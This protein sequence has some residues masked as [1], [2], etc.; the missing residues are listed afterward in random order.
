MFIARENRAVAAALHCLLPL[1]WAC[2]RCFV[3]IW[4]IRNYHRLDF[5]YK[6]F[7]KMCLSNVMTYFVLNTLAQMLQW[8]L[9]VVLPCLG[10]LC[11]EVGCFKVATAATAVAEDELAISKFVTASSLDVVNVACNLL[12]WSLRLWRL[13]KPTWQ[14]GHSNSFSR[15]CWRKWQRSECLRKRFSHKGQLMSMSF[16]STPYVWCRRWYINSDW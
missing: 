4:G 6:I 2:C 12:M 14:C 13:E 5:N 7:A 1:F 9:F 16:F 15:V 10:C 11:T 3:C 8:N